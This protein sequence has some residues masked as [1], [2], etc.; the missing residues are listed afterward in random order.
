MPPPFAALAEAAAV[1]GI[2]KW[3]E[4]EEER[5]KDRRRI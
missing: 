4:G 2:G 1:T 3:E 5:D